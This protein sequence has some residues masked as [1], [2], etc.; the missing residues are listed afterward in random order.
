VNKINRLLQYDD[1]Q[2]T[3]QG[4]NYGEHFAFRE[5]RSKLLMLHKEHPEN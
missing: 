3:A 4:D 2:H 1:R 5:K